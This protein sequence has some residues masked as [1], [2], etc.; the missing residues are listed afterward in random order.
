MWLNALQK[1]KIAAIA[2]LLLT[3]AAIIFTAVM[4]A[5]WWWFATEFMAYMSAFSHLMAILLINRNRY[6]GRI[7]DRCAL[8]FGILFVIAIII[9]YFL[10]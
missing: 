2:A 8:V 1:S 7:L 4:R 10:M 3:I 9:L 5:P 6:V